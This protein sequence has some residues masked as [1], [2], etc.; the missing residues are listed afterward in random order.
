[1]VVRTRR[2][3][4]S[5]DQDSKSVV[6]CEYCGGQFDPTLPACPYCG[7]AYEPGAEKQY[8]EHLKAIQKNLGDLKDEENLAAFEPA[9]K[10]KGSLRSALIRLLVIAAVLTVGMVSLFYSLGKRNVAKRKA[11]YRYNREVYGRLDQLYEDKQYDQLVEVL[12]EEAE[13][14]HYLFQ[15]KH[16]DFYRRIQSIVIGQDALEHVDEKKQ[17][18]QVK[19]ARLALILKA[20]LEA[21]DY[22]LYEDLDQDERDYLTERTDF[23]REDYQTR[24]SLPE[25]TYD[26]FM[27]C[28]KQ[29]GE[30]D[31]GDCEK[32]LEGML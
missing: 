25:E 20:E 7:A 16:Y 23:L 4:L 31:P 26:Y 22:S 2:R 12:N 32:Y 24:F 27:V 10:R 15:W 29:Y 5:R 17:S 11:E 1:M 3:S 14:G 18:A 19:Q 6:T 9:L 21:L 13:K 8:M 30:I 28:L